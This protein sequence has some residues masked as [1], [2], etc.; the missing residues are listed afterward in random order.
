MSIVGPACEDVVDGAV[1][2]DLIPLH[3]LQ[4][5]GRVLHHLLDGGEDIELGGELDLLL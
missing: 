2:L 5:E 3:A 1:Q 4:D